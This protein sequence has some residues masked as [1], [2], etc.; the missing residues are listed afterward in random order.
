MSSSLYSASLFSEHK[1]GRPWVK[2]GGSGFSGEEIKLTIRFSKV[3]YI[4][5]VKILILRSHGIKSGVPHWADD[6]HRMG[7]DAY[8]VCPPSLKLKYVQYCQRA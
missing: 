7:I 4:R 2:G 8:T 3:M 5:P 6:V 1:H